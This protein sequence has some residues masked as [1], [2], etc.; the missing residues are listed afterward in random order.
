MRRV[1]LVFALTVLIVS[2]VYRRVPIAFLRAES[3]WFLCLSHSDEATQRATVRGFFTHSSAGHYTPLAFFTEF[4]TAKIV[5]TSRTFWRW[6]QLLAVAA[7]A[8]ALFAMVVA[9]ARVLTSATTQQIAIALAL[10]A[11]VIFQPSM[12]DWVTCPFM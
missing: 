5:G 9:I 12:I 6:R 3:G 7:V 11:V 4:T 10:T 1:L 8:A 2:A